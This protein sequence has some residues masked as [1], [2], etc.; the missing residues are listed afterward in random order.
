MLSSPCPGVHPAFNTTELPY[1]WLPGLPLVY[2]SNRL[3]YYQA[4]ARVEV[5][6]LA[7]ASLASRRFPWLYG[8]PGSGVWWDPGR[9]LVVRDLL[10]AVLR[11]NSRDVLLA[12]LERTRET[13]FTMWSLVGEKLHWLHERKAR[14][15]A[16]RNAS[17]AELLWGDMG[18]HLASHGRT[19]WA[20]LLA[21]CG[22]LLEPLITPPDGAHA[23]AHA[24]C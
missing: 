7:D 23:L 14:S 3:R 22:D 15:R 10:D 16:A 2:A 13:R 6:S 8:S 18:R 21:M 17:W 4:Q 24:A 1:H 5:T 20:R 19:N 11:W 9:S 12:H